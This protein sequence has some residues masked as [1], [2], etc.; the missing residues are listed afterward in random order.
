[1]SDDEGTEEPGLSPNN[2]QENGFPSDQSMAS[3]FRK[4][5]A[6]RPKTTSHDNKAGYVMTHV[7]HQLR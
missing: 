6:K 2:A 7:C 4:G 3:N 5:M 1:M